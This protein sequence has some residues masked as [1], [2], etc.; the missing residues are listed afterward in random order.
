MAI[1]YEDVDYLSNSEPR[2]NTEDNGVI[3]VQTGNTSTH[4]SVR[5]S[6]TKEPAPTRVI[7]TAKKTTKVTREKP[8]QRNIEQPQPPTFKPIR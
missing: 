7:S 3:N 1:V 6:P 4:Q 8:Q 5:K 2:I